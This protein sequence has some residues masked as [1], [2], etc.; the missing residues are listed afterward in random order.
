MQSQP[1]TNS[2]SPDAAPRETQIYGAAKTA[3]VL[4]LLTAIATVVSVMTRVASG[5]DQPTLLESLAAI[6]A[7]KELYSIGGIAR[8][9]SGL[10]LIAAAGCVL[11]IWADGGRWST[12]TVPAIMIASGGFTAVSGL[13]AIGLVF[14]AGAVNDA[15]LTGVV[16]QSPVDRSTEALAF[17][18]WF[19]GKIG[20]A[21][22][23]LALMGA[24]GY[25]WRVG[26]KLKYFG[27]RV[28]GRGGCHAV[29]LG[30]RRHTGAPDFRRCL[31]GMAADDGRDAG[32]GPSGGDPALPKGAAQVLTTV[33]WARAGVQAQSRMT[34]W[35]GDVQ[36]CI[37]A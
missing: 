14:S 27:C 30:R 28:G 20:F 6:A 18:R 2:A 25:H 35:L 29:H 24:A 33:T 11:K 34:G 3:G 10:T 16:G 21:A 8:L 12:P 4:L 37:V 36:D 9:A 7:N 32:T 31:S 22:A 23:G 26:G 15:F 1:E 17:L 13:C 19:T 5:A